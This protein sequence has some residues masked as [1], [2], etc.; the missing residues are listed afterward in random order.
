MLSFKHFLNELFNEVYPYKQVETLGQIK[1]KFFTEDENMV[2]VHFVER[3]LNIDFLSKEPTKAWELF[4]DVN[5]EVSKT[6]WGD[7]HAIFATVLEI[8]KEFVQEHNPSVLVFSADKADKSRV[9]LYTTMTKKLV[10][11]TPFA[12]NIPKTKGNLQYFI[13]YKP[14]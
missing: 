14:R 7:A 1:Y 4:F 12:Y 6:G 10:R 2:R 9:D 11:Q 3:N 13:L 5:G 8:A